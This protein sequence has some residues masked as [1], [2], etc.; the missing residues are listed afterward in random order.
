MHAG[1]VLIKPSS[2]PEKAAAVILDQAYIV[3]AVAGNRL[4]VFDPITGIIYL[5]RR[6]IHDT[7]WHS[8]ISGSPTTLNVFTRVY[9]PICRAESKAFAA[10]CWSMSRAW[11]LAYVASDAADGRSSVAAPAGYTL[12][13]NGS[14][15]VANFIIPDSCM[16]QQGGMQG[17]THGDWYIVDTFALMCL[18]GVVTTGCLV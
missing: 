7:Y 12:I 6:Q 4:P 16:E 13:A 9:S 5:P 8:Q 14:L 10:Y 2:P 18:S 3:I 17:L 15:L 1:V 11:V